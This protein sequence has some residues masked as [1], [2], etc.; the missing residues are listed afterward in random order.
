[1]V[2]A[3]NRKSV[4]PKDIINLVEDVRWLF[5]YFTDFVLEYC[6]R[7]D[8]KQADEITKKAHM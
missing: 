6:S 7:D 8:N 5:S 2:K 4:V 1:M 3:V